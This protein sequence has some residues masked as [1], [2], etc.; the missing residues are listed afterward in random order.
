[1]TGYGCGVGALEFAQVLGLP[2]VAGFCSSG[3][4]Y[5]AQLERKEWPNKG[6]LTPRFPERGRTP[7]LDPVSP[8]HTCVSRMLEDRRHGRVSES[9]ASQSCVNL[10]LYSRRIEA[11]LGRYHVYGSVRVS[12]NP[13]LSRR[14]QAVPF[15]PALPFSPESTPIAA[16]T[17][18]G[19]LL[20]HRE[21]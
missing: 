16:E 8:S 6:P 4:A 3:E 18:P 1:M 15:V 17:R 9:R 5:V 20:D 7:V 14:R 10:A 2:D 11:A 13:A 12:L 21:A 19:M